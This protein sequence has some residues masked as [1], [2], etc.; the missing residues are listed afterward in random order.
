MAL[1]RVQ[2]GKKSR[3]VAAHCVQAGFM[4]EEPETKAKLAFVRQRSGNEN[5]TQPTRDWLW[6]VA[7]KMSTRRDFAAGAVVSMEQPP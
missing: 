7:S 6:S 3:C 4:S 2:F 1:C 5:L